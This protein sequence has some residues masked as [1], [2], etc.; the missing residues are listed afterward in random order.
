MM[1]IIIIIIII[2]IIMMIIIMQALTL[3]FWGTCPI[4]KCHGAFTCPGWVLMPGITRGRASARNWGR[5]L[6]Y[7]FP[8]L[9]SLSG[10][11]VATQALIKRFPESIF[12]YNEFL[13]GPV[14]TRR[15]MHLIIPLVSRNSNWTEVFV[16]RSTALVPDDRTVS[17]DFITK[18]YCLQETS[19]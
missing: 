8:N 5:L 15:I 14:I 7:R 11:W 12:F 16:R 2:L 13:T 17:G 18:R 9:C 19:S 6:S 10:V 1:M 3:T 4:G